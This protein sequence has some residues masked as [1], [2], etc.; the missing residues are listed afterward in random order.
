MLA[1]SIVSKRVKFAVGCEAATDVLNY[2]HIA[3]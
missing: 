2:D 3:V 1:I